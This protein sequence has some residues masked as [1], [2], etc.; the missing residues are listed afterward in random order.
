MLQLDPRLIADLVGKDL[1]AF[2]TGGIG[3]M[4]IPYLAQEPDIKLHGVTNSR[5][6][7]VDAGTFLD[8]RLPIR[9]LDTWAKLIPEATILLCVIR[10]NEASA[11]SACEAAGFKKII[12]A[13]FYLIEMLQDLYNPG[14]MPTAH[15]MLRMM[16]LANELRDIHKASFEIGRAHV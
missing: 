4:L 14:R 10:K 12:I 1:I 16:C 5:V 7:T 6:T 8:T 2:G 3:K 15:P 9:S 13:P 11:W